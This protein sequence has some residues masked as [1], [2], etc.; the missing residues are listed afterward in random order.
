MAI[1]PHYDLIDWSP[2]LGRH[3]G[4]RV[5]L[6]YEFVSGKRI[7]ITGAAGSI[8]AA[9]AQEIATARP[10][11]LVLFDQSELG[12]HSLEQ[13]FA[14]FGTAVDYKLVLGS[15]QDRSLLKQVIQD[16]NP[17]ILFHAAA[18]KHV[19]LLEKNPFAAVATNVL[20]TEQ[21]LDLSVQSALEQCILVSTDK[22]VAPTSVMGATKRVAECL[23]LAPSEGAARKVLR[24]GNVLGSSGSAV[25]LF[26]E[27]IR[28]GEEITLTHR[29]ATRY[30]MT[31]AEA[32]Y[33]LLQSASPKLPAGLY[34]PPNLEA[35]PIWGL[36][37]FL[38]R[39][40]PPSKST[41]PVSCPGLRPG[42]KA[43]EQMTS[44][45]ERL[46]EG[47]TQNDLLRVI[48]PILS[49][50]EIQACLTRLKQAV[51]HSDLASLVAAIQQVVP[52]YAPSS[53]LR[54]Q[55]PL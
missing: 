28:R 51:A 53:L 40:S 17:Q 38:L 2:F 45:C 39:T 5:H 16:L 4:Q 50:E 20:A 21:V 25:P 30:F 47:V 46:E 43:S 11:S 18:Y 15:I 14:T 48:G 24:L 32:I 33:C 44:S 42:E 27:Q 6:P 31:A 29:H 36:A 1:P 34:V 41:M 35:Q 37:H 7:L 23:F 10:H 26:L 49:H 12:L 55:A 9:L 22:A 52:E 54:S 3:L 8:G 13:Q 19:P